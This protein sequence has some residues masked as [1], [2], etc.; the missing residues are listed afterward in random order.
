[1]QREAKPG[2]AMIT[3][4]NGKNDL[5]WPVALRAKLR[6]EY[7]GWDGSKDERILSSFVKEHIIPWTHDGEEELSNLAWSCSWCNGAK[8]SWNPAEGM[9][10]GSYTREEL[11]EKVKIHLGENKRTY[12]L[13]LQEAFREQEAEHI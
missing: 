11:I 5:W 3:S 10:E 2:G 6:C 9:A 1:M 13:R 12:Y 4:P 7:C 8:G